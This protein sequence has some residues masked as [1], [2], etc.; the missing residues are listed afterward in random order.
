MES[1][2]SCTLAK[3]EGPAPISYSTVLL[4]IHVIKIKL[5]DPVDL[6]NTQPTSF[7][8]EHIMSPPPVVVFPGNVEIIFKTHDCAYRAAAI[9]ANA[10]KPPPGIPWDAED[11]RAV[12]I[13]YRAKM[14]NAE[15]AEAY[16]AAFSEAAAAAMKEELE[17]P[18][19][20]LLPSATNHAL[21]SDLSSLLIDCID[22]SG[23][24]GE[25]LR[26]LI[27]Q[28]WDGFPNK[29]T[30]DDAVRLFTQMIDLF[31]VE[32]QLC[33]EIACEHWYHTASSLTAESL[34][35][36]SSLY[37]RNLRLA[38]QIANAQQF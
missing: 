10:T 7:L 18:P 37:Q 36:S 12:R 21:Y 17:A 27:E 28:Q 13:L 31:P 9:Y 23:L 16:R 11:A 30:R 2:I 4:T 24:R 15:S 26:V 25:P 29:K 19:L 34:V 3:A 5:P 22:D 32:S 33:R 1:T 6:V 38:I 35:S 8:N 20:L 14:I